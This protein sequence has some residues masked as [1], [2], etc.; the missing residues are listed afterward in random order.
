LIKVI[1]E[2]LW[3]VTDEQDM[4][5]VYKTINTL[6][7]RIGEVF[8]EEVAQSLCNSPAIEVEVVD[9]QDKI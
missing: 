5:R 9:R 8:N 4:W 3:S 2:R 6:E 1:L 7:P